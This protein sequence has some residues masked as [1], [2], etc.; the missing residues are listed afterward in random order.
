METKIILI[1]LL[2]A[3]LIVLTLS[4]NHTPPI[5][6]GQTYEGPVPQGYSEQIFRDTGKLVKIKLQEEVK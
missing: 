6:K 4:G 1:L 3:G 2:I 5:V